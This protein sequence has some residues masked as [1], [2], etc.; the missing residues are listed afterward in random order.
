MRSHDEGL[1]FKTLLLE[2]DDVTRVMT[3]EQIEAVFDLK[4]QL[5]HVDTIFERVFGEATT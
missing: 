2:D 5:R 1:D 3:P 4:V